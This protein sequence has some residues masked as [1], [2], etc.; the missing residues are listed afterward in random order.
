L[1][2]T[3]PNEWEK[4]G[5]VNIGVTAGIESTQIAPQWI[6]KSMLMDKIL[7]ISNHA[8]ESFVNTVYQ[9]TNNQT[10]ETFAYKCDKPIECTHYPVRKVTP[11]KIK[12]DLTTKF[13]FLTV[14]QLGPRKN[15]EQLIKCFIE[16]FGDNEDVGLI[17][18]ANIA[19]NSLIDRVNTIFKFKQILSQYSDRKCKIYLLHGFLTEE[20]MAGLYTH[21]KVKAL[22]SATH[23]E[24]FGLPLF[25]AAYNSL[26]VIATDWSGHLDFLYMPQKQKNGKTKNKH[27]F[28]KISYTLAPINQEAVWDGVLT[29]ESMW[30][31]P[32]EGSIKMALED[33]YKDHG[34]FK[35]RA[36]TLQKWVLKEFSQEKVYN[37]Y[38]EATHGEEPIDIK[39]LPKVSIITSV[40]KGDEYIK[41]FLED[42]TNQTIFKEKC[43]LLLIDANSPGNEEEAIKPYLEKYPNNIVYKKLDKDPGIYAVWNIGVEMSTGEYLT[44]ANLDDRHAPFAYEKQASV[45]L[46]NSDVDLVYSDMLITDKPNETWAV[47]SSN[48]R[49]YNFPEFSYDHLKMVNMPHAAPMWRKS[50]HK[51]HGLFD[52]KYNSAGDWEMWLRAAQKGSKF[53][54]MSTPVGLYY[55]NPTGISTNPDNFSWKR[56]EEKEIFEKYSKLEVEVE[57]N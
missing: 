1:Q 37:K 27:M 23:G 46:S 29:K 24:G 16:Q 39:D 19:K 6:E 56:E 33:M 25:E 45:L 17:V 32:E 4:I 30:A 48:E 12:L 5:S 53:M 38:I 15:A 10:G 14:A 31:Y 11:K 55:F 52:Q 54:K 34:R 36:K 40:Y 42:I 21:P 3:I 13:N 57:D 7:T 9:A 2:V 20:E 51:K 49:K 44:N 41:Q 47:N 28:S 22:V 50:L 26:P 8:V 18:K 43:E 35:K